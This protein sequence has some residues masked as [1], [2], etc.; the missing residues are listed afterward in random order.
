MRKNH[1]YQKM[2]PKTFERFR[3]QNLEIGLCLY[4]SSDALIFL[5]KT[6]SSEIKSTKTASHLRIGLLGDAVLVVP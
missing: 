6:A 2:I 4:F 5:S 1:F 3:A